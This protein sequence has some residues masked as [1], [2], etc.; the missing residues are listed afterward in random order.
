MFLRDQNGVTL[1]V[2]RPVP[3]DPNRRSVLNMEASLVGRLLQHCVCQLRTLVLVVLWE[4]NEAVRRYITF[5]D[6]RA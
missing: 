6:L 5:S 1:Q 2:F 4:E 3:V